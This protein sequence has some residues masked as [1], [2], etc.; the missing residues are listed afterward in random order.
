[1]TD[2]TC[3]DAARSLGRQ[4][5]H[6]HQNDGS[7]KGCRSQHATTGEVDA[8]HVRGIFEEARLAEL[9]YRRHHNVW[10]LAG[11]RSDDVN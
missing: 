9:P 1:M 10:P 3:C 11:L 4:R 7:R 6:D 5:G 2:L 8:G